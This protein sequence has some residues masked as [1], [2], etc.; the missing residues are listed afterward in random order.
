MMDYAMKSLGLLAPSSLSKCVT[1]A[2]SSMTQQLLSAR[3]PRQK[4][5]RV[6]NADRS[7]KKGI[8]AHTVEDLMNKVSNS[9]NVPCVS[10]LV[11]DEDGT[12]VDTED[13]FQTL[14]ENA[15][16][17]VLEKGQKWT[18]HLNSSTTD[19]LSQCRPKHRTD[20]AR[21]T[22]DLYKN[23]PKDFIGCLNVKATLYG[24]YSV[25]YDLRCYAAKKM[26]KEALRWAIFSMQATGHILLGSSCYIEQLLEEEERA[27]NGLTLPQESR[28]KQL[29]GMLLGKVFIR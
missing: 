6:T 26:L 15:V 1:A 25:S 19:Q 9:L 10:A 28:I 27:E 12:G 13:F 18:P 16:L 5:F 17:M 14:P 29:Q 22:F 11:L 4:P 23:N 20:V 7:V 2:S 21:V 8:M 3:P 24:A